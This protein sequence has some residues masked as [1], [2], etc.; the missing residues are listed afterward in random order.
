MVRGVG[1]VD[2]HRLDAAGS[3][4][5]DRLAVG[6]LADAGEDREAGPLELDRAGAAD[7]GRAARDQ[8]VS[9]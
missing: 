9:T 8:D 4:G 6:L 7:P 1:D 3:G 2:D 5:C